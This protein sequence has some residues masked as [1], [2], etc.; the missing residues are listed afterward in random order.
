MQMARYLNVHEAHHF[1]KYA[2]VDIPYGKKRYLDETKRLY[3]V[4]E[5]RLQ[6]RD[7]L[8]GS[9]RGKYSLA[10]IKTF[11][12]VRLYTGAGI[13]NLDEWPAV[14]AWI[15]RCE[16]RPAAQAGLQVAKDVPT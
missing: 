7:Y 12:W 5:G 10:D 14:K 2:P 11:P 13:E 16:S 8:A 1:N 3:S 4:L 15:A 9:G 6:N